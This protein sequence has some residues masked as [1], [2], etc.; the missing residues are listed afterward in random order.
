MA[1]AASSPQLRQAFEAHRQETEGHVERLEQI[2]EKLGRA[3]RGKTCD[4]IL[5]IIEESKEIMRNT[6]EKVRSTPVSR[7]PG[8]PSNITRWRAT[9]PSTPGPRSL[10]WRTPQSSSIRRFRKKKRQMSC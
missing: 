2:F 4:A 3:A 8:R 10:E 1:K 7:P 9:A 6:R 5:G